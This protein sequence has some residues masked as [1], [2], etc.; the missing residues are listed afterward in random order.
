MCILQKHIPIQADIYNNDF[1]VPFIIVK[2]KYAK[3][4]STR[5][6]IHC[7]ILIQCKIMQWL[8]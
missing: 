5:A 6:L 2:I 4:P 3:R 8:N 7:C 1:V